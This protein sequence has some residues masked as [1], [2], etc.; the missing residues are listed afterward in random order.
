MNGTTIYHKGALRL[1]YASAK[2]RD[3]AYAIL[4]DC[5]AQG[6]IGENEWCEIIRHGGRFCVL[7]SAE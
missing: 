4:E 5:W 1:I 6:E 3:R 7:V 2:T